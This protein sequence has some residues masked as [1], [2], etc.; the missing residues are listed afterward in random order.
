MD[1]ISFGKKLREIRVDSGKTVPEISNHLTSL[2]FKAAIQTIYG[3][4]RGHSQPTA[5]TVMAMCEFYGVQ[6]VLAAFGYKNGPSAD[7]STLGEEPI[8]LEESNQ[9]LVAL[10]FI[11][12]GQQLSDDDLAFL[13]NIL[14][15]LDTWFS[16]RP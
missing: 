15:L 10:G 5:D 4:E 2:G 8:S 12:E 16:K 9:L 14:G 7:E 6:D 11:K 1:D 3:W 13:R